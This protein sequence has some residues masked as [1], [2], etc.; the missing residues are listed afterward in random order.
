MYFLL[1]LTRKTFFES[2]LFDQQK[3][4]EEKALI[5]AEEKEC[6]KLEKALASAGK[7]L[8]AKTGKASPSPVHREGKKN[9]LTTLNTSSSQSPSM[10]HRNTPTTS[11]TCLVC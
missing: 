4:L 7:K 2:D 3:E 5:I 8:V 6:L 10:A 9:S 1:Q 11:K